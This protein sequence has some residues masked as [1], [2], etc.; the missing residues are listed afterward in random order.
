ML[1]LS[2][3]YGLKGYFVHLTDLI[4]IDGYNWIKFYFYLIN[5][6]Y[7]GTNAEICPV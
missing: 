3:S 7:E 6:N 1:Q 2:Y 4:F 5:V